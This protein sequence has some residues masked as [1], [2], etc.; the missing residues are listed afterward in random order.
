[1]DFGAIYS[2]LANGA[3]WQ[4]MP[5]G[6]AHDHRKV[7]ALLDSFPIKSCDWHV[8]AVAEA[9]D[10]MPSKW[11]DRFLL[12]TGAWTKMPTMGIF[13]FD[14]AQRCSVWRDHFNIRQFQMEFAK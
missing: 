11:T 9:N 13:A 5:M 10:Q 6:P 12:A 2:A 7:Q 3:V 1:M 8:P 14:A 4:T